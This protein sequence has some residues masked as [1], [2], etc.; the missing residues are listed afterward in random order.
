[1]NSLDGI[2]VKDI[3]FSVGLLVDVPTDQCI[4]PF[5]DPVDVP[6][7]HCVVPFDDPVEFCALHTLQLLIM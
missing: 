2:K 7:D 6:T 3:F 1:M 4:V 5:D